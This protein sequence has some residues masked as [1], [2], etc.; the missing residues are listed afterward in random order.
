MSAVSK[1]DKILTMETLT[2][3]Y[4][5]CYLTLWVSKL[6]FPHQSQNVPKKKPLQTKKLSITPDDRNRKL[7][8]DSFSEE[9]LRAELTQ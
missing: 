3:K 5:L 4:E 1:Y 8:K 7:F 6:K 2:M 9:T